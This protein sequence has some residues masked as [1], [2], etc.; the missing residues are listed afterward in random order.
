M[1]SFTIDGYGHWLS[2]LLTS[3]PLL[4]QAIKER[5]QTIRNDVH[6]Y[7][8]EH[9]KHEVSRQA[10]N[11]NYLSFSEEYKYRVRDDVELNHMFQHL[12]WHDKCIKGLLNKRDFSTL[13][14][15]LDARS[16]LEE[17]I[18]EKIDYITQKFEMESHYKEN[19]LPCPDW[20]DM[21][22]DYPLEDCLQ[23]ILDDD[24]DLLELKR[25]KQDFDIYI[26]DILPAPR[27]SIRM[28]KQ[29]EFYYG[30]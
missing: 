9:M 28:R 10:C 26:A 2:K 8:N 22:F 30:Y 18:T 12:D 11:C 20:W 4:Q 3:R 13:Q 6:S 24:E 21:Q 23:F 1:S 7:I 5:K 25:T 14:E 19:L 29:R 17:I 27:R 15:W 16:E